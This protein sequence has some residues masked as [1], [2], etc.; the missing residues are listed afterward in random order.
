MTI[1]EQIIFW[2]NKIA[3]LNQTK[4]EYRNRCQRDVVE[5]DSLIEVYEKE[6]KVLESHQDQ[7]VADKVMDAMF[8]NSV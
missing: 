3:D 5:I 6:I 7:S 1:Q 8:G 2:R 4:I